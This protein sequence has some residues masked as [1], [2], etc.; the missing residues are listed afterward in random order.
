[1]GSVFKE[2]SLRQ[3]CANLAPCHSDVQNPTKPP[4]PGSLCNHNAPVFHRV[5]ITSPMKNRP[6]IRIP[7]HPGSQGPPPQRVVRNSRFGFVFRKVSIILP[8][9]NRSEIGMPYHLG[10]QRPQRVIRNS[11]SGSVFQG[12]RSP[13]L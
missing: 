10:S 2:Y 4:P 5:L 9:K 7:Y 3:T 13:T 12:L 8:M 11:Y 6:K 1:M